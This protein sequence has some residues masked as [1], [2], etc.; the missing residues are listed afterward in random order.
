MPLYLRFEL[1][2]FCNLFLYYC[3]LFIIVTSK[4]AILNY[5]NLFIVN[6][7]FISVSSGRICLPFHAVTNY[8]DFRVVF[9]YSSEENMEYNYRWHY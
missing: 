6:S 1:F 5:I 8:T 3:C 2:I 9:I 7:R 4:A